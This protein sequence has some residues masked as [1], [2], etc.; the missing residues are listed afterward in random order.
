MLTDLQ[1]HCSWRARPVGD[2]GRANRRTLTPQRNVRY[3]HIRLTDESISI[4]ARQFRTPSYKPALKLFIDREL[5][6]GRLRPSRSN[7]TCGV[8]MRPE[9]DPSKLP[10]VL[11]RQNVRRSHSSCS[12][13]YNS[14]PLRQD[15]ALY[16]LRPRQA[17]L[18][19]RWQLS[20]HHGQR[21]RGRE[22]NSKEKEKK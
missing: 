17:S 7:I 9:K 20:I 21:K 8:L 18:G 2:K 12:S 3:H 10:H 5:A 13:S 1:S 19:S 15:D 22:D 14:S 6:A 16:L 11:W 4:N